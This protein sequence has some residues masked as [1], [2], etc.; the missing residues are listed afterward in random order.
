[1]D[2]SGMGLFSDFQLCLDITGLEL[3]DFYELVKPPLL[4][5]VKYA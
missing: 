2:E 5:A 3:R 4:V 1:M